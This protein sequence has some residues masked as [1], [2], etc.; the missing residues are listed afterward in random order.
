MIMITIILILITIIIY[1]RLIQACDAGH[2]KCGREIAAARDRLEAQR[3]G[4]CTKA[5][6]TT[7]TTTTIHIYI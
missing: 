5:R 7:T 3:R 4:R 1:N 2:V 6:Y